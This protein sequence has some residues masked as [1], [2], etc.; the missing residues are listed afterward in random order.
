MQRRAGLV[1]RLVRPFRTLLHADVLL[2]CK[3]SSSAPHA[4]VSAALR[5]GILAQ[6]R[7]PAINSTR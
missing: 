7:I 2:S 5:A 1:A 6:A 4:L 3:L